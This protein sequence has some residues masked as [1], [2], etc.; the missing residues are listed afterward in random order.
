MIV[1]RYCGV[2]E[3]RSLEDAL[4]ATCARPASVPCSDCGVPLCSAHTERCDLCRA[5]LC[6]SCLSFHNAQHSKPV[7]VE[8]HKKIHRSA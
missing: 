4:G 8:P 1:S 2:F 5:F 3:V 7:Q 6:G